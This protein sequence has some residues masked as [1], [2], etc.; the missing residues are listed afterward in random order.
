MGLRPP[1]FTGYDTMACMEA[2]ARGEMRL[3]LCLGGNLFGSN[4]DANSAWQSLSSLDLLVYLSTSL[5]TGHAHGLGK[6]TIILPVLARDEEPQATTQESMFNY[7]RLSDGGPARHEGPRSEVCVIA[8]VASRTLGDGGAI[9]W[10]EVQDHDAIR[11]L[12]ANLVPGFGQIA[13]VGQTKEEFSIPGRILH[14]PKFHTASGKAHFRV[15]PIPR[16]EPLG[17]MQLRMMTIRSEGQFN[18]VV[19]E[20]EDPYRGQTRRD[21]VLMNEWDIARMNLRADQRVSVTS[22]TGVLRNV[23]VRPFDIAVG[24]CAAYYPEANVLVPREVD[25]V[26]R[27]PAFK[28]VVVTVAP[29]VEGATRADAVPL[30]VGASDTG[31]SALKA[32]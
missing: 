26:S 3:G 14:T 2:A 6:E 11:R 10:R 16:L 13:D 31:R 32:C 22:D 9:N 29:V 28:S 30:T 19:Y 21:V 18:T 15:H 7:V 27:T 8:E 12:V 24:C 1:T 17:Q 23:L 25:P 20:E 5:N 4:P